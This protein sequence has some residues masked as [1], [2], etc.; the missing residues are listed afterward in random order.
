MAATAATAVA[1]VVVVGWRVTA[2][3]RAFM[4]GRAFVTP[5][6]VQAVAVP[7]GRVDRG[8][9]AVLNCSFQKRKLDEAWLV[10]KVGPRLVTLARRLN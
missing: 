2:R 4:Q 8:E 9:L 6:D 1:P 5:D 7:L 3:A 10:D